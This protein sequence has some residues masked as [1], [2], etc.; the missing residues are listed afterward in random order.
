MKAVS[1]KSGA[2]FEIHDQSSNST[3]FIFLDFVLK[4]EHKCKTIL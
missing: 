3:E 1:N 4:Y 2:L